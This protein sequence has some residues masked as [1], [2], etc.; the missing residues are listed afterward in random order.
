MCVC[1]FCKCYRFPTR[2][3]IHVVVIGMNRFGEKASAIPS[4]RL[5]YMR[6]VVHLQKAFLPYFRR[7]KFSFRRHNASGSL[8][9]ECMPQLSVCVYDVGW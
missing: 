2:F 4:V 9:G 5:M 7:P 6:N 8:L 1:D 3:R